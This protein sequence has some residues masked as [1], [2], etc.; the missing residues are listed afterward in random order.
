MLGRKMQGS[1]APDLASKARNVPKLQAI[2]HDDKYDEPSILE[3]KTRCP[4]GSSM[5]DGTMIQVQFLV[6]THSFHDSG[7]IVCGQF[8]I[9]SVIYNA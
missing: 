6:S 2:V 7:C 8:Y 4:C 1:G 5:D 9:I 3:T